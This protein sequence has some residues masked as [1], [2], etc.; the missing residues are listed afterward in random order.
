MPGPRPSTLPSSLS[1][2]PFT[3]EQAR[4]AGVSDRRLR[5]ADLDRRVH[6]VRTDEPWYDDLR[7]RCAMF[8]RRLP[9]DAFFSH[10]T[11]ALLLGLP[12][13]LHLEHD[14]RLHATVTAPSRAPHAHGLL[15]HSRFVGPNDVDDD[16]IRRSSPERTWL[17]LAFVLGLPDLVAAGDRLISA[18]DPLSTLTNLVERAALGDRLTRPRKVRAALA[19]LDP[20]SESRP[21]SVLRVLLVMAG[22]P[23]PEVNH[24]VVAATAGTGIRTDL[25][26]PD[27][28]LA[29]EYQG[30]YHRERSQWRADLSRR[31]RLEALG[32]RVMELGAD[33]LR[34]PEDL[35]A[36]IRAALSR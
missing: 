26:Y 34:E 31:G 24:V 15:G 1:G 11:A 14:V 30:D 32:W 12:L 4:R 3:V 5:A 22:L 13:P 16:G 18:H 7:G 2:S 28:M 27:R 25:A 35:V 23:A 36:R 10:T 6:G 33:D 9:H 20:R 21:E 19:L 17:E 29:I 8:A